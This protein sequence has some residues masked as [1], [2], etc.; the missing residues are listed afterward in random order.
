MGSWLVYEKEFPN[1]YCDS[2]IPELVSLKIP[3]HFV[4]LKEQNVGETADLEII[5]KDKKSNLF[6]FYSSQKNYF[7]EMSYKLRRFF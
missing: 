1:V 3:S 7:G 6:E 4:L 5:F 2:L